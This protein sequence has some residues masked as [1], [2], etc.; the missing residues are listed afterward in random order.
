MSEKL[1]LETENSLHNAMPEPTTAEKNEAGRGQKGKKPLKFWQGLIVIILVGIVVFWG[2]ETVGKAFF[3]NQFDQTPLMERQYKNALEKVRQNPNSAPNHVELGWS[4][5]QKGQYNDALAEYKK[6]I[7]LDDKNYRAYY[8]LGL[9]YRQVEKYDLAIS[10]L[11]KALEIAPKSFEAHYDL[12]L[13]YQH[14]GKFEQ[15]LQEFQLAYKLNPGSTEIIYSIGQVYEKMGKIDEAKYQY[16]SA[17]EFDPKFTKAKE[18][19]SRLGGQ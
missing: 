14:N 19:L 17:L 13:A 18:A 3:W 2:G 12:G 16:Q 4:L 8:D 10:S 15:A 1:E 9:A 5:F 11:Q 6:A 7:D